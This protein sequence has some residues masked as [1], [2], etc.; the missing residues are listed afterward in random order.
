VPLFTSGG[1]AMASRYEHLLVERDQGVAVVTVNRPD[2]LNALNED[3]LL[4]LRAATEELSGGAGSVRAAILTG[5]GDR[6]FVAGADIAAMSK[7]TTTEALSFSRAG[8]RACTAIEQSPFPWIAAVNGFALGGG[9]ELA[10]ACDFIYASDRAKIGQPEV[11]LGLM[12][13]FG[14]TQRL[15][16]R[17]GPGL[18][19][20]M[21]YTAVP[22]GADRALAVGLVNEVVPAE[23][24]MGRVREVAGAIASKAP[25]A[26]AA[27]KR[28]ILYGLETD[29]TSGNELEMNAFSSL[30]GTEDQREGTAAF[31]EKRKPNFVGR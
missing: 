4:Q 22:L 9:C 19:R 27:S 15:A 14:G 13:G 25:L 6:A 16:R 31:L 24:L 21:V 20:E 11:N 3:V 17:L 18:A 2:K 7:M 26:I 29:L 28:A 5:A 8:H 23:E 1:R 30:F 10:L 12:P